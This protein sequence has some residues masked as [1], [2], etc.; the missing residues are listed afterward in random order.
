MS[1]GPRSISLVEAVA[2]GSAADSSVC[3]NH[4][5]IFDFN[6]YGRIINGSRIF[7]K[8]E[9]IGNNIAVVVGYVNE[10]VVFKPRKG[11]TEL[12]VSEMYQIPLCIVA[13]TFCF[14]DIGPIAEEFPVVGVNAAL[15]EII[16][17]LKLYA[18][19]GNL[20]AVEFSPNCVT[21]F[22]VYLIVLDLLVAFVVGSGKGNAVS[23][24]ITDTCR[25][26]IAPDGFAVFVNAG[27]NLLI[28]IGNGFLVLIDNFYV[29]SVGVD[30]NGSTES[31]GDEVVAVRKIF[32]RYNVGS[33]LNRV[34]SG[35][36]C[37]VVDHIVKVLDQFGIVNAVLL[38]YRAGVGIVSKERVAFGSVCAEQN[39]KELAVGGDGVGNCFC[40]FAVACQLNSCVKKFVHIISLVNGCVGDGDRTGF[41]FRNSGNAQRKNYCQHHKDG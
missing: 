36:I 3:F 9:R 21:L 14:G 13:I 22:I 4:C 17:S 1:A 37:T 31:T 35:S 18:A 5:V 25:V 32:K 27:L 12:I 23:K 34:S 33:S 7:F 2:V 11:N 10:I 24:F 19:N 20:E 8:L 15:R 40:G 28:E 38:G 29:G 41:I 39:S 30:G 16:T 26:G 6:K